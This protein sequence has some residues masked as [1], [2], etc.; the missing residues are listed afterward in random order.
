MTRTCSRRRSWRRSCTSTRKRT[1]RTSGALLAAGILRVV[2]RGDSGRVLRRADRDGAEGEPDRGGS[3]G[4]VGAGAHRDG[5]WGAPTTRSYGGSRCSAA[6]RG[7]STTTQA[8]GRRR[9]LRA[10]AGE[11]R[12]ERGFTMGTNYLP[13]DARP[14]TLASPRSVLQQFQRRTRISA[15][16]WVGS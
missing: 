12:I 3:V 7:S 6:S 9:A 5:I 2:R 1:G 11:K 16:G 8:T 10:S 4:A 14:R 13:H 15:A